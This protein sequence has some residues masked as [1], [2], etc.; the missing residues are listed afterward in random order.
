MLCGCITDLQKINFSWFYTMQTGFHWQRIIGLQLRKHLM[1]WGFRRRTSLPWQDTFLKRRMRRRTTA[2]MKMQKKL[3]D[4]IFTNSP[5]DFFHALSDYLSG[6]CAD[7]FTIWRTE[8]NI[9]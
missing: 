9:C 5:Q 6:E 2:Q 3:L 8:N 1:L 7:Q 4:A